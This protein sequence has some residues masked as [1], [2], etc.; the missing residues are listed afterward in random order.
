LDLEKGA[1]L[2]VMERVALD[3]DQDV[4][5]SLDLQEMAVIDMEER[6]V[7]DLDARFDGE[8]GVGSGSGGELGVEFG[9]EKT[10]A[11]D[12]VLMMVVGR[13]SRDGRRRR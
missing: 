2:D 1:A 5:T 13:F 12:K 3:L 4:M 8:G 7:V 11:L 9:F 10:V 6:V